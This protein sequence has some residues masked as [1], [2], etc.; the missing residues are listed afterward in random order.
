MKR[1]GPGCDALLGEIR[2]GALQSLV[3]AERKPEAVMIV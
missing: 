2:I 3:V 1:E